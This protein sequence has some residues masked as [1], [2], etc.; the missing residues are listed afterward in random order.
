MQFDALM[1][2]IAQ[3]SADT[4]KFARD[5]HNEDKEAAQ[6]QAGIQAEHWAAEKKAR[7]KKASIGTIPSP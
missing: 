3:T 6:T 5:T 4:L 1:N 2:V 7:E